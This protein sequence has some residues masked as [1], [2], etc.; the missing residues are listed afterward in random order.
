ME[1]HRGAVYPS[2]FLPVSVGNVRRDR[3]VD[4]YRWSPVFRDLR[5]PW[6][7]EG[8]CGVCAFQ[9][10]CGGSRARAYAVSGNYLGEDP[11]CA[12]EPSRYRRDAPVLAQRA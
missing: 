11:A 1:T 5:S 7:L 6:K 12:Y 8:K 9:V 10:V 2:G 3:L 4:L